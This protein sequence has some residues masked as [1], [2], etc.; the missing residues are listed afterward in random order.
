MHPEEE[1][2]HCLVI[3][4][5]GCE[6]GARLGRPEPWHDSSLQQ[7][8]MEALAKAALGRDRCRGEPVRAFAYRAA[9]TKAKR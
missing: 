5:P 3:G 1:S 4:T 7:C 9:N 6:S 8:M 2:E